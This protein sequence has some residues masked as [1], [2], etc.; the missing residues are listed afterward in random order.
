MVSSARRRQRKGTEG[1]AEA[2]D[3]LAIGFVNTCAW[4]LR[5]EH[6]ERLPDTKALLEWMKGNGI[7]APRGLASSLL[8]PGSDK[9]GKALH[10]DAIVLREAIYTILTARIR[11]EQPSARAL[12]DFNQFLSQSMRGLALDARAGGL[13]WKLSAA[14]SHDSLLKP[15]LMSAAEL[16]VGTRADRVK[17]CQDDRGCGWLF[18]DDSRAQNRRWCSMGDCGNVAK[19]RRH[20]ER[21]RG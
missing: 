6:E 3:D 5:D 15:I 7:E 13:A 19:A 20:Y 8:A 16:M 10:R 17:Q 18:V 21:T 1:K 4:R 11:S 2:S 12:S 14:A 9:P